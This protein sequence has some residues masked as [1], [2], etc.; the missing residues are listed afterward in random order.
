[1]SLRSLIAIHCWTPCSSA[2]SV[3]V[4][5][6]PIAGRAKI[7]SFRE[8][9]FLPCSRLT[10]FLALDHAWIARH[11]IGFAKQRTVLLVHLCKRAGNTQAHCAGLS[12]CAAANDIRLHIKAAERIRRFERTD[13]IVAMKRIREKV[14]ERPAIDRNDGFT[15]A[16]CEKNASYRILAASDVDSCL[17]CQCLIIL[18]IYPIAKGC[19]FCAACSCSA[20]A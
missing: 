6:P 7:L 13:H 12:R 19:G 3:F 11:Q 16:R 2:V 8:L 4:I 20:P 5:I 18:N 14:L 17:L 10:R 15:C 9:E 1:M